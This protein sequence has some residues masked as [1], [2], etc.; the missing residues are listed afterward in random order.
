V[1]NASAGISVRLLDRPAVSANQSVMYRPYTLTTMFPSVTDPRDGEIEALELEVV[2][3]REHF[4]MYSGGISAGQ[5]ISRRT[6]L[7]AGYGYG[8]RETSYLGG[9]L[10]SQQAGG[11]MSLELT[12][13]LALRL[14]YQYS[15]GRYSGDRAPFRNH[16]ADI[17]LRFNRALS[18]T[19]R[20][21]FSFGTG[22]YATVHEERTRFRA[23]A[24]ARLNH[25]IGRTWHAALSYNRG[26]RFIETLLQP[27]FS[28]SASL[29]FGG[30]INRR[31]RFDSSAHAS[32][33]TVGVAGNN[34]YD[35]YRGL[36]G[37][38]MA[39]TRHMA[40]SLNYSYYRYRFDDGILLPPGVMRD[41]DRQS[42]RAQ[43]NMWMPLF[44]RAR[45]P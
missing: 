33:G 13:G 12:R 10:L 45:R 5:Q 32:L 27:V 31:L 14:G 2:P 17:G 8:L 26:M 25:E 43:V 3:V 30:L 36:A 19:R 4:V 11:G 44:Q 7:D 41:L 38:S 34:G 6:T 21:T 29:S 35:T 28:D 23:A 15:E 9:R 39:L 22:S 40:V 42:V 24:S 20:T 16:Q 37:L 18:L 1:Y